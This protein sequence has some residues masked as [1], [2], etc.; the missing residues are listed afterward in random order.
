MSRRTNRQSPQPRRTD[1]SQDQPLMLSTEAVTA[2]AQ[3]SMK[4]KLKTKGGDG[5]TGNEG[6]GTRAIELNPLPEP[7]DDDDD[8]SEP[9]DP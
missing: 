5:G 6:G 2:A 4:P 8:S 1:A 7:P 9:A 3:G